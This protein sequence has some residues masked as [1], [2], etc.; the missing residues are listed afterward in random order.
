MNEYNRLSNKYNYSPAIVSRLIEYFGEKRAENIIKELK[1]P[2]RVFAVRVN[3]LMISTDQV[4]EEL[5][6]SSIK[7]TPH[8]T[9]EDAILLEVEGPF[10]VK[11]I[12]KKVIADKFACESVM[13]GSDLYSSGVIKLEKI[14]VS[15]P[16]VIEDK[17]GLIVAEGIAKMNSK[18]I[19]QRIKGVAVQT[20][21]SIYKIPDLK[22]SHLYSRGMIYLQSLPAIIASK[23]LEPQ[24]NEFVIDMC[25]APGGKTTHIAQIMN[26]TGKIL[27]LDR[28][29]KRLQKLRRNVKR[30]GIKNV[31]SIRLDSRL[32]SKK[33]PCLEAD[34]I[35]VDPPCTA[36]GVRPKLYD[37]STDKEI[38]ST[39][40]YQRQFLKV[41]AKL[42]KP[43]GT[44]V[45]STCTLTAEENESN[46]KYCL[47]E[48][49]LRLKDLSKTP[50]SPGLSSYL[51]D[52]KK[53]RRFHPDLHGTPAIF[54]AS[55]TKD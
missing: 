35:I 41:A 18:S 22:N 11:G 25:A 55:L 5:E 50:G 32:L 20:T 6:Q 46:I 9:I 1:T 19:M 3:S 49:G 2:S 17:N 48:L 24:P 39:S 14:K 52:A 30:L 37:N 53:T 7:A 31:I 4:L 44:I 28:S 54:I 45:Y 33:Y 10:L 16:V 21:N 8:P 29:K 36:I 13:Q 42:L 47:E 26:N 40:A 51:S 34:R 43:S 15:D 38:I 27:A 12:G 23:V